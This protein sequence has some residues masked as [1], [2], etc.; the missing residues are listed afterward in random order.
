MSAKVHAVIRRVP[1]Q[2]SFAVSADLA[3]GKNG[4]TKF[5]VYRYNT[6]AGDVQSSST[7]PSVPPQPVTAACQKNFL[8]FIS[9]GDPIQD[10]FSDSGSRAEGFGDF[11]NKLIGDY[12]RPGGSADEVEEGCPHPPGPPN[13]GRKGTR[14]SDDIAYFMKTNDFAPNLAGEQTIDTYTVAF[15]VGPTSEGGKLLAN[16]TAR[17][18]G[19]VY[20]GEQA[21]ELADALTNAVA[22]IIE[23]SENSFATASVPASRTSDGD[24]FYSTYFTPDADIPLWDPVAPSPAT[25]PTYLAEV[26]STVGTWISRTRLSP[27]T[28]WSSAPIVLGL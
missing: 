20:F 22:D 7:H 5:P 16:T 15:N 9:D 25:P 24:S 18:G 8:I 26:F 6:S 19:R 11:K 28:V 27:V 23:K 17:G 12:Y 14:Y 2:S 1:R 21:E 4:S 3:K 10:D 13:C